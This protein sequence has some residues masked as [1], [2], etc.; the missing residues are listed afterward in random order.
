[1]VIVV[2]NQ[3][4]GCG[5]TMIATN[6]AAALAG[7]GKDVILFDAD[8]QESASKW[9]AERGEYQSDSPVINIGMGYDNISFTLKDLRKRYEVVVVDA[10]G[11]DSDEFRTSA[12]VADILLIPVKPSKVDVK[13]LPSFLQIV[14]QA[15]FVNDALK[16]FAFIS[17]AP[18]H[19][20][21]KEIE[22]A[23]EIIQR[24]SDFTLLD[25]VI[26]DRKGFRDAFGDGLGAV[27]CNTDKLA[28]VEIESLIAEVLNGF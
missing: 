10:A 22:Q 18:T 14:K 25:T 28:K 24:I 17:I 5:K 23:R 3:K 12:I 27:E 26:H 11:R 15:M 2:G 19:S 1:M 16:V 21:N 4:G 9:V 8:R 6:L 7:K 13:V 20:K